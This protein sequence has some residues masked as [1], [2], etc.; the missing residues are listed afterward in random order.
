L[1]FGHGACYSFFF[2]CLTFGRGIVVFVCHG[3]WRNRLLHFLYTT[4]YIYLYTHTY[5]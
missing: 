3:L 2:I 5:L 1:G 4:L